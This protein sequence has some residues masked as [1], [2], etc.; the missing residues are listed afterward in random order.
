MAFGNNVLSFLYLKILNVISLLTVSLFFSQSMPCGQKP[1]LLGREHLPW[2]ARGRPWL[3]LASGPFTQSNIDCTRHSP[4]SFL[5]VQVLFP[6]RLVTRTLEIWKIGP[7]FHEKGTGIVLI[8]T[9]L[10]HIP[11]GLHNSQGPE[12][13]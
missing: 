8:V 5:H 2:L 7:C 12:T 6:N 9:A 10:I 11:L 3:S 1:T 13:R 4:I